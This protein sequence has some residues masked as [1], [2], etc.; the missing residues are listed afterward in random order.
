M[1]GQTCASSETL[2]IPA[3]GT[4]SSANSSVNTSTVANMADCKCGDSSD[5]GVYCHLITLDL[6]NRPSG[7]CLAADAQSNTSGIEIIDASNC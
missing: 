5:P 7:A 4:I 3:T 6:S 1:S 2:I